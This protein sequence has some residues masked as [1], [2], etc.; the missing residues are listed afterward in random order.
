MISEKQ[1]DV[2]LNYLDDTRQHGRLHLRRTLAEN[3]L[4]ELE[5]EYFLHFKPDR[6]DAVAKAMAL[7]HPD[8]KLARKKVAYMSAIFEAH[9]G[10]RR[11]AEMICHQYQTD[12][13]D[14]RSGTRYG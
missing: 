9:Q 6:T 10:K 12:A 13:A 4:K 5:S 3:A 14:V 7:I 11:S 8:V 1:R 2:A